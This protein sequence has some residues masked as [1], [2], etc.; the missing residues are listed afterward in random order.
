VYNVKVQIHRT[1][2]FLFQT[3]VS[4]VYRIKGERLRL[5]KKRVLSKV[6]VPK[7]GGV[8]GG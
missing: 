3:S 2:I 1:S 8:S 7:R 5:I 6:F 4:F